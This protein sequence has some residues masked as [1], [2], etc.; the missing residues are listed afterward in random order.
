[1]IEIK[2]FDKSYQSIIREFVLNIQNIEF[3]LGFGEYEQ[4]DLIDTEKFYQGG[5][6]WT[7]KIEGNIVGTIGLQILDTQNA[8]LRKMFV[9][10]ELRGRELNIAQLLFDTLFEFAKKKSIST[11]WLDTPAVATASH[12]FYERNGFVQTDKQTLPEGY[13]F[14]DKDSKIYKLTVN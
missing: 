4:P 7:A 5:G 1:V 12:K 2:A 10:K 3:D 8:V 11:I 9:K 13:V 14:P 6:F